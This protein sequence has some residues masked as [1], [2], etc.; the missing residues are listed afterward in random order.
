MWLF[1]PMNQR[2]AIGSFTDIMHLVLSGVTV[3]LMMLYI[4]LG[5]GARGKWFRFYSFLT[6]LAI[7]VFG[8]LVGLQAPRVAAQLPIPWMGVMERVMVY[9]PMLWVLVFAVVQLYDQATAHQEALG[10]GL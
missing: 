1:F 10:N 4:G 9:S 3:P 8:V 7:L 5:S 6:I 2:G